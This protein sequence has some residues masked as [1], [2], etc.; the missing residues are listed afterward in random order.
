M[1]NQGKPTE[2]MEAYRE[3]IKHKPDF[4]EAYCNLGQVLR[5]QGQ[6]AEAVTM[7]ARGHE[8]GSKRPDW[9][10]PSADWVR[11]A[12]RQAALAEKL[13]AFLQGE[14]QPTDAAEQLTPAQICYD[15]TW[16]VAS[17]R[18][19][20]DA[21]AADPKLVDLPQLQ[22]RYNAA[23]SA[24]LAGTGKAQDDPPPDDA[25]R[26][27][28]RQQAR[29]WLQADLK[30]YTQ[31]LADEKG[32]AKN[33]VQQR[34]KHWQADSDLAGLRAPGALAKLPPE[35]QEACRQ[36]WAEVEAVLRKAEAKK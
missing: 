35:E 14:A 21:F 29:E 10:Y 18:F 13:P 9:R 23:C 12:V 11:G 5:R 27:K 34:L 25:T 33:L 30:V 3:A 22:H 36:L 31:G 2:A 20:S 4:A 15:R 24:A 7:L 26:A 6:Y 16:Y 19:W 28:L 17:T 8:L 1:W 32:V